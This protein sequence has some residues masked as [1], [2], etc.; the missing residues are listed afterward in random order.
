MDEKL[1][2]YH[3]ESI[4]RPGEKVF[5]NRSAFSY[6]MKL[7]AHDFIEIAYISSGKGIHRI[8]GC[9]Y[10]VNKGSLFVINYDIPHRFIPDADEKSELVVYNCIFTPDFLDF[11]L[12]NNK[13]FSAV[14]HHFLFHSFFP[15]EQDSVPDIRLVDQDSRE[16]EDLYEKLFREYQACERGYIEIIRAYTIE[17][18]ITVF[19]QYYKT[20]SGSKDFDLSRKHLIEKVLSHIRNNYAGEIKLED[21]AMMAFLSPGYFCRQFKEHTGM[22]VSEYT[23]KTRVDKACTLLRSTTRKVVDIAAEVGYNDIKHFNQV[24]KRITG[25]TPGQYRKS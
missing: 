11:S 18:L 6:P 9:D 20:V 12:I 2:F 25:E 7:H 14:A 8:G 10:T 5:I 21:L 23:Q 3:D 4:F 15:V 13:D 24:F 19:R 17:L 16:I 22:T 1:A